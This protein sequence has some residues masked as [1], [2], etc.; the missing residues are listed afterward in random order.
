MDKSLS[1]LIPTQNKHKLLRRTLTYIMT[2]QLNVPVFILDD[3]IDPLNLKL[4]PNFKYIHSFNKSFLER[5][6][7]ILDSIKT[8]YVLL[9]GDDDFINLES[10]PK[11]IQFLDENNEFCAVDGREIRVV[12][13]EQGV[14]ENIFHSQPTLKSKAAVKRLKAHCNIYWPTFYAIHR[15]GCLINSFNFM[16][17]IESLGYLYQELGASMMTILQGKFKSFPDLYLIRQNF[18]SNSTKAIWW[19]D[20]LKNPDFKKNKNKFIEEFVPYSE[21]IGIK[22]SKKDVC[23]ALDLY[24]RPFKTKNRK[25]KMVN[26]LSKVGL[27]SFFVSL[28]KIFLK[29]KK[30]H[31]KDSCETDKYL[32]SQFYKNVSNILEKHP[33]GVER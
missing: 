32:N 5:I 24:L 20:M 33:F 18:H 27:K 16:R 17:K 1:I 10:I 19:T 25:E 11:L 30:Y 6:N 29:P 12:C 15:K 26:I 2:Q 23:T 8:P 22:I 4:S 28:K 21:E 9:I 3:S 31:Q 13:N 14:N 7:I